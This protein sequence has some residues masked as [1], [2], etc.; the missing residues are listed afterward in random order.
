MHIHLSE[1]SHSLLS[2]MADARHGRLK[3]GVD[4][5]TI[6]LRIEFVGVTTI[7]FQALE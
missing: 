2:V 3:P 1:K 7:R 5:F 6:R 4:I